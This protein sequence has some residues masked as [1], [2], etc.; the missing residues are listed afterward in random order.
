M[1]ISSGLVGFFGNLFLCL[2]LSGERVLRGLAGGK[3]RL[4]QIIF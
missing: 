4:F 2:G 3:Y 1:G